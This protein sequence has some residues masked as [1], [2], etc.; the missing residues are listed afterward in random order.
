MNI[1]Y[2]RNYIKLLEIKS[3]SELAKVLP[4][5]QSTLSHQISMIE[6]EFKVLLIE[7]STKKFKITKAGE[8][9]LKH[10]KEIVDLYDS[11]VLKLSQF[12]SQESE[13]IIISASSIPGSH[14]LPRFI[15]EFRNQ[16]PNISFKISISNSL[17]S[18]ESLYNENADFAGIGS[19]ISYEEEKFD[20]IKL[21]EEEFKVICSPKHKLI[22]GEKDFVEFEEL[23]KFPFVWREKGS[24]MRET[25]IQQFPEYKRLN[26]KLELD[27]NDSIIST[28]SE[29]NY[30]SIM[31]EIMAKKSEKAGLI[32]ILK[33]KEHL[34]IAK[35]DLF[36]LK[37]KDKELS[38]LKKLFWDYMN[39]KARK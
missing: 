36:F 20:Y 24:G 27:D 15:A 26:L 30:I 33:I 3:F 34:T 19:F 22:Q 6:K 5:S 25:I 10:A 7:R 9:L 32:K 39:N 35:R 18:I 38:T 12:D 11:C 31:S 37:L 23:L 16:H 28:V 21:G 2:L 4:I 17:K 14:I 1:E 13:T 8:E 29:S